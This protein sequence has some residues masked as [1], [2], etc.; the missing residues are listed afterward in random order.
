MKFPNDGEFYRIKCRF[1]DEWRDGQIMTRRQLSRKNNND[2]DTTDIDCV[3]DSA[4][5]FEYYVHYPD[6]D[7]RLDEWITIRRIDMNTKVDPSQYETNTKTKKS[8]KRSSPDKSTSSNGKKANTDTAAAKLADAERKFEEMTKVRNIERIYF[9]GNEVNAWYYSPF[10]ENVH[11]CGTLYVCNYCLKYFKLKHS[12]RIHESECK[13]DG[14][15]GELIYEEEN[16]NNQG[17]KITMFE[18]EGKTNKLYC[19]NLCLLSK[20]FLDH[21]TLYFDVDPFFF[22]V[23]CQVTEERKHQIVG[24]FS[25]EK[26][27]SEGYN[28]ACI[29]TFPVFQQ[30]G[31]GKL[32]ISLSYE[33]SKR[34]GK[35]GHPEK[36]LSDL[37]RLSYYS[38]WSYTLLK[39]MLEMLSTGDPIHC[40]IPECCQRTSIRHEDVI[41]T[42]DRLGMLSTWKGQHAV[43]FNPKKIKAQ[44]KT[45]K[46]V[47]ACDPTC[48]T[49]YP[50]DVDSSNTNKK[51][52]IVSSQNN[53]NVAN[54]KSL[55]TSNGNSN[56]KSHNTNT[57]I[58]NGEEENEIDVTATAQSG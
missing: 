51:S 15:P 13:C 19:Q 18:V 37:G 56:G 21:K 1:N 20:L 33:L 26:N 2:N 30:Q 17:H 35:L 11:N 42:F 29:L 52:T 48:L 25:K 31:Y 55:D 53:R 50:S 4:S 45:L 16:N 39:E 7:R 12:F 49:W 40:S 36:P 22:Y 43:S 23:L 44:F 14:P 10:P 9:Y 54:R 27:S 3:Q 6:L 41:S 57:N 38:Y 8:R 32:L 47:R 24:Y 5:D 28:L 34:E 46:P 58:V